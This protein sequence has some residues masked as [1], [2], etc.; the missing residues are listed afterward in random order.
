MENINEMNNLLKKLDKKILNIYERNYLALDE[1]VGGIHFFMT[2]TKYLKIE[3]HPYMSLTI[4]K[5]DENIISLCHYY[6]QNGDLMRDPEM[7]IKI[8]PERK[9]V[10]SLNFRNDGAGIDQYVYKKVN[11]FVVCSQQVKNEQNK[12]L[13]QWL[14]NLKKQ[15]FYKEALKCEKK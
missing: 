13:R 12:F 15:G 5:V 4:E 11:D 8:Y 9:M 14:D 10:E 7:V 3:N 6:E 2:E 1:L